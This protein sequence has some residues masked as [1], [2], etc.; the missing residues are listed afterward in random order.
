MSATAPSAPSATTLD[1]LNRL[2]GLSTWIYNGISD[3]IPYIHNTYFFAFAAAS[4]IYIAAQV[5]TSRPRSSA[6]PPVAPRS[7]AIRVPPPPPAPARVPFLRGAIAFI[8][9]NMI[10]QLIICISFFALG[11]QHAAQRVFGA[12]AVA[13]HALSGATFLLC[14]F[15]LLGLMIML[16]VFILLTKYG[17]IY[18][19]SLLREYGGRGNAQ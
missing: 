11:S 10:V 3:W 15:A 13:L 7:A 4:L 9:Y 14:C 2:E 16:G 19:S 18:V 1:S 6:A 12:G 17:V 8:T 5:F